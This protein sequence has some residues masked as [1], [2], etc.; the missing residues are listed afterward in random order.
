MSYINSETQM[1]FGGPGDAIARSQVGESIQRVPESLAATTR[2]NFRGPK[3]SGHLSIHAIVDSSA[4]VTSATGLTL[5]YSNLRNPD[6][7]SDTDWVQD[8]TV[9]TI[10]AL[11]GTGKAFV[12]VGNLR[13]MHCMLKADVTAGTAGIRV[14]IKSEHNT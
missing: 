7:T 13:A 2:R 3:A 14:F 1:I 12:N 10:I 8:T 4:G 9:G 6:P 5:W 11:T